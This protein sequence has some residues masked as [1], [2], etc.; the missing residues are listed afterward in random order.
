[1]GGVGEFEAEPQSRPAASN[2]WHIEEGRRPFPARAL[3]VS[4]SVVWGILTEGGELPPSNRVWRIVESETGQVLA[5][6]KDGYGDGT[7][8]GAQLASELETLSAAEFAV[9]WGFTAD[10]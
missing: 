10:L 6:V 2:V 9:R 3:R 7:D 5:T 4:G 8:T 1:M